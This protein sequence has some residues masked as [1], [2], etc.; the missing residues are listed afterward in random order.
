MGGAVVTRPAFAGHGA[1]EE[2]MSEPSGE[3]L[4]QG[5]VTIV[6]G[7]GGDIGRAICVRY[8]QEGARVVVA[9]LRQELAEQTAGAVRQAGG[10]A[11]ALATDVSK[12]LDAE[13]M[14]RQT[15]EQ[16]GRIDVLVNCAAMF[17]N[18]QRKSFTEIA[19]E[20]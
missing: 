3:G 10:A 13:S 20:E 1:E 5:K 18:I 2:R 17:G 14:A 4:L 7:A 6:T 12:W 9:E 8:A 16:L 11:L 19:E 15:F